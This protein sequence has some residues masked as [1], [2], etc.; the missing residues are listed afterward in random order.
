M[1]IA[2]EVDKRKQ[3]HAS[4]S[5]LWTEMRKLYG[6]PAQRV[7]DIYSKKGEWT[8]IVKKNKLGSG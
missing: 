4:E 8:Q 1:R 7:K 6:I 2:E 3:S 5:G